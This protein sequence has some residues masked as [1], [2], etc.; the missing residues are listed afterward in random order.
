MLE[1]K[2]SDSREIGSIPVRQ[3]VGQRGTDRQTDRQ[4]ER[5]EINKESDR[6][7][8]DR[9]AESGIQANRQRENLTDR[10]KDDI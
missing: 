4:K 8:K 10:R 9:Q 6:R 3:T 2:D 5:T 7:R 1:E